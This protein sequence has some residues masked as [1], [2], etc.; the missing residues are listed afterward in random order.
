MDFATKIK[1]IR[2][3]EEKGIVEF[4]KLCNLSDKSYGDIERGE[5]LISPKSQAKIE[6][7]ITDL[8]WELLE[9][10]V[11]KR[12]KTFLMFEGPYRYFEL[13]DDIV[14]N[15]K[16]GEELLIDGAVESKTPPNILEKVIK[17]RQNGIKM[18]HLIGEG[19]HKLKAPLEEYR[20]VPRD[21]FINQAIFLYE[22]SVAIDSLEE[23]KIVVLRD[24]NL[25]LFLKR[26][27]E[28]SWKRHP[29]PEFTEEKNVFPV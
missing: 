20:C 14:N 2:Y 27:F 28:S 22:G 23:E 1:M 25:F 10:G 5:T 7:A 16:S 15:L 11:V 17:I 6:K 29:Q 8:G 12:K 9:D 19:D 26:R 4:A 3:A 13:F 21:E 24:K 18:R